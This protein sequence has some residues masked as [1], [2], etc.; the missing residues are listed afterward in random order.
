[1]T[2][3]KI[4]VTACCGP[5]PAGDASEHLVHRLLLALRTHPDGATY[6]QLLSTLGNVPPEALERRITDFAFAGLAY[7]A[8]RADDQ[9]L[10]WRL[11][12][13]GQARAEN[14]GAHRWPSSRS[15]PTAA[16]TAATEPRPT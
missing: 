2:A 5:V 4:H 15:T 10:V 16:P 8:G 7:G 14:L 11:T 3:A 9:P 6:D 13:K 12:A 1:M